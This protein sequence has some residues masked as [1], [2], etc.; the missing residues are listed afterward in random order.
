MRRNFNAIIS[1]FIVLYP[2]GLIFYKAN[3][4]CRMLHTNF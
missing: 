3:W 1:S 2:V 4:S